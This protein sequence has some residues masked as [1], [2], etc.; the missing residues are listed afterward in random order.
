MFS[1]KKILI[2]GGTG[3]LGQALTKKIL[4]TDVDT[5]RIY[6][7]NE[8]KQINMESELKDSRLRFLIGD[9]RDKERLRRAMEDIDIVIHA[10]ALKHINVAEYNPFEAVK[11]NV[12]GAQNIVECCLDSEIESVLAVSTDKAVSPFNTYGA[13]KFLMERLF[14][15]A[16]FYK[17]NR[18]TNFFCVRYGNVLGSSGSVIPKF[19]E[20]ILT[21]K[22]VTITDPTMTR[23]NITMNQALDL[24][25]RALEHGQ[26]GETFIPK[27]KAYQLGTL[28][29]ALVEL[30]GNDTGI[31]RIPVRPGEK[32]HESLISKDE[33]RNVFENDYD[34]VLIDN[35]VQNSN[36]TRTLLH[37]SRQDE[38]ISNKVPQLTKDELKEIIL[39]EKI[40]SIH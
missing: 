34:Y 31:E 33:M 13:T 12:Y 24:I 20:Q 23:F 7:R 37:T 21:G 3:S 18:Q 5:I 29:D 36:I 2:T 9:I 25:M 11:T 19:A 35:Q 4:K 8:L 32:F 6:S 14:I 27:L 26:G 38:Y 16:N 10:A 40:L 15:S 1:G 30:L 28:R 17:G 39:K 22:K